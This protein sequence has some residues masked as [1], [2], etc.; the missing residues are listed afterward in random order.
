MPH[1]CKWEIWTVGVCALEL[2]RRGDRKKRR[3]EEGKKKKKEKWKKERRKEEWKK[4]KRVEEGKKETGG[5]F[6]SLYSPVCVGCRW[7]GGFWRSGLRRP[8]KIPTLSAE[9]HAWSHASRSMSEH[10]RWHTIALMSPPSKTR[11]QTHH[12]SL[13][14]H[15][16][17]HVYDYRGLW[18][19]WQK[20]VYCIRIT[21]SAFKS[22]LTLKQSHQFPILNPKTQT[23]TLAFLKRKKTP[24]SSSSS[25]LLCVLS[26]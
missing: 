9:R 16:H 4:E 6:V 7:V 13:H 5:C 10:G 2:Q 11:P 25:Q 21:I 23:N 19:T 3:V 26:Y 8:C 14:T 18:R 15:T 1:S 20:S 12:P 24:F 17:T 22:I